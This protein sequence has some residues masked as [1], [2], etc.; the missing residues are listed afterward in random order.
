MKEY[1]EQWSSK[2]KDFDAWIRDG[3]QDRFI[4]LRAMRRDPK[5]V[6]QYERLTPKEPEFV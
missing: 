3:R 4:D 5:M 1:N 2:S 6:E